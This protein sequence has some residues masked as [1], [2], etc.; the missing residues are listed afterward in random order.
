MKVIVIIT[1]FE[2]SA[3]VRSLFQYRIRQLAKDFEWDI[4]KQTYGIHRQASRPHIHITTVF[5]CGD[6]KVWKILSAKI[7]SSPAWTCAPTAG[8]LEIIDKLEKELKV[9]ITHTYGDDERY[10]EAAALRYNLKEYGDDETMWNDVGHGKTQGGEIT[11]DGTTV[12]D[13]IF[14]GVTGLEAEAMR[15][16]ANTQYEAVKD[17]RAKDERDKLKNENKKLRL[18]DYIKTRET[19]DTV[20]G[21]HY[22]VQQVVCAILKFNKEEK[23]NFRLASLKDTAVNWLYQEGYISEL[24]ICE[25]IRI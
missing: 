14:I 5:D 24:E 11:N 15:R 18:F 20:S 21:C 3:D 7:K 10:D 9:K 25:L 6:K 4:K 19:I 22:M 2:T 12:A 23:T 13:D 16:V 17:K 8:G 1:V